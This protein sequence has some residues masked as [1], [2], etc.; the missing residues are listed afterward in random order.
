[1]NTNVCVQVDCLNDVCGL[2][3]FLKLNEP[4]QVYRL[5]IALFLHAGLV[6]VIIT[7][8][9]ISTHKHTY[10]LKHTSALTHM[11]VHTHTD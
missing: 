1:M 11:F 2:L 10:T 9:C 5:W 6:C 4:D 7:H 3:E 8:A